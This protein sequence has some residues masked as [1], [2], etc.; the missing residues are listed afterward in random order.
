MNVTEERL[1]QLFTEWL[2]RYEANS[3]AFGEYDSEYGVASA[4]YLIELNEELA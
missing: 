4:R 2:R 1:A 3:S